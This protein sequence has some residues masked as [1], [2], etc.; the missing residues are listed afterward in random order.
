MESMHS[1]RRRTAVYILLDANAMVI[2]RFC[3]RSPKERNAHSESEEIIQLSAY[4]V[5]LITK[6]LVYFEI[7]FS[8]VS[9]RRMTHPIDGLC[10]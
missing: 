8:I 2:F 6:E 1:R 5:I 9:M 7:F 4:V 3:K 10:E